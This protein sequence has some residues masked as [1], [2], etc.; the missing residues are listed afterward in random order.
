MVASTPN[1]AKYKVICTDGETFYFE[2][3]AEAQK[4]MRLNRPGTIQERRIE[5]FSYPLGEIVPQ[6]CW[7]RI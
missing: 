3:L 1:S 5:Y 4:W 7:Q 2:S 6:A